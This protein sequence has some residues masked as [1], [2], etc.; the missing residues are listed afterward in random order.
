[1]RANNKDAFGCL[2]GPVGCRMSIFTSPL[3]IVLLRSKGKLS[4]IK[5]CVEVRRLEGRGTRELFIIILN[6]N[7][8]ASNRYVVYFASWWKIIFLKNIF[9]IFYYFALIV[10]SEKLSEFL[11]DKNPIFCN[12]K[13]CQ[14]PKSH[15][16]RQWVMAFCPLE[17]GCYF[18]PQPVS[19]LRPP[20][21]IQVHMHLLSDTLLPAPYCNEWEKRA[22][23]KIAMYGIPII[24][25]NNLR[26]LIYS[27]GSTVHLFD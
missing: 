19:L 23:L 12:K 27:P 25:P 2:R 1:M 8:I 18:F 15:S 16:Q 13:I 14:K 10:K 11:S 5:K 26:F 20:T 7:N 17:R 3:L 6:N 4:R 24:T 22:L 21:L 9:V